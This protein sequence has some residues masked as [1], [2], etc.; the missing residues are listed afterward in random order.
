MGWIEPAFEKELRSMANGGCPGFTWIGDA[1]DSTIW[2][3]L[4]S[5]RATIFVSSAEGFV[6]PPVESL[7][8][9]NACYRFR[10]PSQ[11]G[12][13]KRTRSRDR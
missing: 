10:R 3:Y 5:A 1:D 4:E 7:L 8:D 6:L 9:G 11:S 13:H 2:R 12:N